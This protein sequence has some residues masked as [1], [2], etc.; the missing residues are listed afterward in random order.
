MFGSGVSLSVIMA[1]YNTGPPSIYSIK[2][3][4]YQLRMFIAPCDNLRAISRG[5]HW[6]KLN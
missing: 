3:Q 2:K 5:N 6:K 1:T 4:K